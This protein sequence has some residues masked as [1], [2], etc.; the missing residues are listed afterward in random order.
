MI[1]AQF[2]KWIDTARVAERV[3]AATA[4]SR[5][6]ID[7]QLPF[8]ERCAVEGAL[9]LLLDDPSAKVRQA[10]AETLSMSR[11]APAQIISALACDQPEVACRVIGRSPLMT[12]LDLI[13]RVAAGTEAIQTLIAKR[14]DLS[15]AVAAALAEVGEPAACRALLANP[16]AA[17]ATLSFRRMTERHGHIAATRDALVADRRLPS[18]CRHAL[19][20][21]L[22]DAFGR[23]PFVAALL[24]A[25][26][27]ERVLR[28][29]CV[30]A[31]LA[32]VERTRSVEHPALIE[33][34]RLRGDLTTSFLVRAVAHGKIDFFG[35]A[36]VA[37][38]GQ[39]EQRV[40]SILSGGGDGAVN[41][42]LRKA[43]LA[44]AT[45]GIVV[46]AL[47]MWRE[48]ARGK[49][50]AGTQEVS[51]T[52]L[53]EIGRTGG[54][55]E[56]ASLLKSIHLDALRENARGHALSIAAA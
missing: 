15:M 43:G 32:V 52:M 18:E 4:L 14:S 49:R 21:K 7:N 42:L 20:E 39:S 22:S 2:L 33:H 3:A 44:A 38:T 28:D 55:N 37:L 47:K 9:T 11:H 53:Q 17:I 25:H 34:L 31:S 45:H 10:L 54:A 36:M 27:T 46:C 50:I 24:G 35:A 12:D 13:D 8:E 1:I 41:A 23:S 29:A 16:S 51:W 26:R 30:K 6:Y 19:V 5:A 56:L 40:K 48:V